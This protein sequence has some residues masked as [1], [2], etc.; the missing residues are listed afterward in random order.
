[1]RSHRS[2]LVSCLIPVLI[3]LALIGSLT[4]CAQ[5]SR[6]AARSTVSQGIC[7]TVIVKRGN[8]MPSPDAA[9][10]KGRPTEREVLIFPLMT[11]GQVEM[12]QDGFIS[13]T[14]G[15]KPIKSVRSDKDGKFCVD[16]PTGQYSV[17]VQESK[18]LYANMFDSQNHIFPVNVQQ[19]RRSDV[20]VEISHQAAF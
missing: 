10:P 3:G 9:P 19:N 16:L 1:M 6:K 2:S 17:V 14:K 20:T 8:Q 4:A 11:I 12:D 18:G 7:G 5:K 15:I 13:D